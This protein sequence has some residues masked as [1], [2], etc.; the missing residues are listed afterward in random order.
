[1]SILAEKTAAFRQR[2]IDTL[3]P[4]D[5][6]LCCAPSGSALLCAD[7]AADPPHLPASRCPRC[8]PPAPG[9]EVCGRCQRH[10]PQFDALRALHPSRFPVD[11]LI[12]RLKYGHQLAIARHV[13]GALAAACGDLQADLIVPMPLHPL[14]LA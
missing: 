8:A 12:Q 3:L 2:V 13:G 14:R 11:R 4:Q 9:N 6:L 1:M 5:C 10:P 7:C